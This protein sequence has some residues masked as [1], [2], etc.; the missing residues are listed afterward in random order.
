MA[1]Y[2]KIERKV[3]INAETGKSILQRVSNNDE[4]NYFVNLQVLYTPGYNFTSK[5]VAFI[6]RSDRE[7]GVDTF[8]ESK[9]I[10]E[11]LSYAIYTND[12]YS[13]KI[14]DTRAYAKYEKYTNI[15]GLIAD[16]YIGTNPFKEK[17]LITLEGILTLYPYRYL[18]VGGRIKN[19]SFKDEDGYKDNLTYIIRADLTFPLLSINSYYQHKKIRIDGNRDEDIFFIN[20]T[21][22]F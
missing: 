11:E 20:L 12:Y 1:S 18:S 6:N 9:G 2:T 4:S 5:T 8:T 7:N 16:R 22:R 3:F 15:S 14:L 13:R 21:K 17:T 19:E 10:S